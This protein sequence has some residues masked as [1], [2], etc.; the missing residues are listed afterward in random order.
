MLVLLRLYDE[1]D[2]W[3]SVVVETNLTEE[4]L[5]NIVNEMNIVDEDEII[6]K[7]IE[8]GYVKPVEYRRYD[9]EI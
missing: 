9:I 2:I 8:M 5:Q 7:L 3:I 4:Q 1:N 6:E